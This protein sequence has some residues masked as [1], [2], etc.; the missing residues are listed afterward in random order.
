MTP[1]LSFEGTGAWIR[2]REFVS[3]VLGRAEGSDAAGARA[4]CEPI[5]R[6]RHRP[7]SGLVRC[8]TSERAGVLCQTDDDPPGSKMSHSFTDPSVVFGGGFNLLATRHFAFQ[9]HR[10]SDGGAPQQRLLY[11]DSRSPAVR[12]SLRKSSGHTDHSFDRNG[13]RMMWWPQCGM[14]LHVHDIEATTSW[15]G[16]WPQ[17]RADR[18]LRNGPL[19]FDPDV[20]LQGDA[21]LPFYNLRATSY[22]YMIGPPYVAQ[23]TVTHRYV[24]SLSISLGLGWQRGGG[25]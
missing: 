3:L 1:A 17:G 24:P 18:R 8:R 25:K 10:G 22:T 9:T 11:G 16:D 13:D 12:V 20:F 21:G 19:R 6:G 7:L 14:A 2:Q 5:R 15:E 23:S 4:G